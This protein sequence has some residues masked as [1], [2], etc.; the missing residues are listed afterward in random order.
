VALFRSEVGFHDPVVN[1]ERGVPEISSTTAVPAV[2]IHGPTLKQKPAS[3]P[4]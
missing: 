4:D 3:L 2:W 1:H